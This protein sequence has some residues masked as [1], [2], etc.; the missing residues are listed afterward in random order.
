MLSDSEED[1]DSDESGEV[2]IGQ[3][4]DSQSEDD[5]EKN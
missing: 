5:D 4:S 2:E 3:V 1:G